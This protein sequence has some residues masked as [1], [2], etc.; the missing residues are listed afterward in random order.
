MPHGCHFISL[1]QGRTLPTLV[2]AGAVAAGSRHCAHPLHLFL[3][4]QTHKSPCC[5]WSEHKRQGC[6]SS[7]TP[8]SLAH[9]VWWGS[10]V[11]PGISEVC[12]SH[13][14]LMETEFLGG[15]TGWSLF[16]SLDIS[17]CLLMM[18]P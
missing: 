7:L 2:G 9:M 4:L 1:C 5:R 10:L 6:I 12:M 13:Q 8:Q 15:Y 17:N 18:V 11:P 3:L 14:I 16:L